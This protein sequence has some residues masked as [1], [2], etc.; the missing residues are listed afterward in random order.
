MKRVIAKFVGTAGE[1]RKQ[2]DEVLGTPSK[3]LA[4]KCECSECII[5]P[6][7]YRYGY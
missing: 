3:K 6:Y 7:F 2:C 1:L 5:S 4:V